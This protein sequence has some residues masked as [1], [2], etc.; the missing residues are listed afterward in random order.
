VTR[1]AL[2]PGCLALLPE[3]ASV[4]DPVSELREAVRTAADWLG[5]D[6]TV[7]GG[8]QAR[9]LG[10][11]VLAGGARATTGER[12]YLV[13][14]NGSAC[15]TEKAPGYLDPR[16]EGF[17]K[18]L[19]AALAGTDAAALASLDQSLARELW[20]DTAGLSELSGLLDGARL[21]GIDYDGAPYGVQYWVMR[22][23]R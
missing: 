5:T 3:Y 23:E 15:R 13:V 20:A 7:V 22:W 10:A 16:A 12:S 9:R 2:V 6:A 11:S 19:G 4:I 1:I 18:L 8:P 14:G 17:D 21:V